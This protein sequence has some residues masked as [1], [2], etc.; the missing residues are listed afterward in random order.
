MRRAIVVCLVLMLVVSLLGVILSAMAGEA[1]AAASAPTVKMAPW[2]PAQSYP[3][4][5]QADARLDERVN[6]WG[7]GIPL[8]RVLESIGEQTGVEIG[9]FPPGDMNERVCVNLYLNPDDPPT[10]REMLV[11]LSWV[12]D[13]ALACSPEQPRRYW[14]LSTSA[15]NGALVRTLEAK[16]EERRAEESELS[17][18]RAE[19]RRETLARLADLREALAVPEEDLVDRYLGVDDLLLLAMLDPDRRAT[20]EFL[21]SLSGE[22]VQKLESTW[23]VMRWWS[24]WPP[25]QQQLLREAIQSELMR[26]SAQPDNGFFGEPTHW[27]DWD[28]VEARLA[29]IELLLTGQGAVLCT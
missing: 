4:R 22:D 25:A 14:L 15:G 23:G 17:A 13:C 6:F 3:G 26:M 10:L 20:S 28:W 1:I 7:A 16:R 27:G 24:R 18:I 21:V 5:E 2:L 8:A 29:N 19:L 11:Q 9:C 12:T